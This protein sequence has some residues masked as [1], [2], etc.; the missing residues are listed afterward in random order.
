M[1]RVSSIDVAVTFLAVGWT[2]LYV[3]LSLLQ[4]E[5]GHNASFDLALYAR[6]LWGIAHGVPFNPLRDQ[7]ALALH[8]HGILYLLAPLTKLASPVYLLLTLQ[9]ISLGGAG[10]LLYAISKR[11]LGSQPIAAC[12]ALSYFFYP[13]AANTALFDMHPKTLAMMPI[14]C[15]LDGLDRNPETVRSLWKAGAWMLL[16]FACREDIAICFGVIGVYWL[17]VL[18]RV[19]AGLLLVILS[20]AFFLLYELVV[21]PALGADFASMQAHFGALN[22]A[23]VLNQADI[24]YILLLLGGFAFLPLLGPRF[25]IGATVPIAI[26]ILSNFAQTN[27][28]RSHYAFL[29]LPFLALGAVYGL[30]RLD[31]SPKLQPIAAVGM[32]VAAVGVGVFGSVGPGGRSFDSNRFAHSETSRAAQTCIEAIPPE[33]GVYAPVQWAAHLADRPVIRHTFG[34]AEQVATLDFVLLEQ[35]PVPYFARAVRYAQ[36]MEQRQRQIV[37]LQQTHRFAIAERCGPYVLLKR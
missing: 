8:S 34:S 13:V 4:Y 16:C 32:V 12:V 22:A 9:A 28:I 3:A 7:H 30:S 1:R 23:A 5:T 37:L 19:R 27:A 24:A 35:A 14:L 18:R 10:L 31:G 17:L 26:N 20:A 29:A 11:R 36:Y 25:A 33:A 2:V 6:S 21:R 15:V